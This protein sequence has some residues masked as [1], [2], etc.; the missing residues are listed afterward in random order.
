M[1]DFLLSGVD[2]SGYIS[3]A[4]LAICIVMFF[5]SLPLVNWVF[6]D[7]RA[8]ET[9][10][11]IWTGLVFAAAAGGIFVWL[12]IPI[13]FVGMLFYIVGVAASALSY[14]A[15]RNARVMD[16]ERVLTAEHIKSLFSSKEKR[17]SVLKGLTFIT[18]NNNEVPLPKPKTPDFFGYKAAHELF[19]DAI[20]RRASE[21]VLLPTHQDYRLIYQIDGV[22]M[23][24]PS[25]PRDQAEYFIRFIKNVADLVVKEKRKPQKGKF[26][27][28][29][30]GQSYE[31]ELTTAGSTAGE[32]LRLRC[33]L[34]QQVARLNELGLTPSQQDQLI[35]LRE[36]KQGVFIV[37]GPPKSGLTTTFYALLRN[38]DPFIN[39]I[40]TLE[41]E[42]SAELPN[43]TQEVFTLSDSGTTTF[44]NKLQ[45]LIRMGPD[46]VG[47]AECKDSETAR[48]VCNAAKDGKLLYTILETDSVINAL[49]LWIKLVQNKAEALRT[50]VGISNQRLLRKLCP[51]CKQ[52]YVPN[53]QLLKKFG[54]G[55]EK[56]KVL[57]RAGKVQY[58]K[59]GKPFT[60]EHCQGTGF[61]GRTGVFE[62]IIFDDQLRNAINQ[63]RS[64]AE[65]A[66]HL[67]GAKML[68][69]QEQAL[70]K[71]IAGETSINEIIR[72]FKVKDQQPKTNNA[73]RNNR[74]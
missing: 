49:L 68:Y 72:V 50:L 9:K 52:A 54:I 65:I 47:V 12:L 58:D 7:A 41:R 16:Y 5:L 39:S 36:L 6:S 23:K 32:Q 66:S 48:V 14:V 44:A 42:P 57:Y 46:I 37:S 34:N 55:P 61:V 60:C 8:V 25:I 30:E 62:T 69:L 45:A 40:H 24:R 27:I 28:E 20:W 11:A 29:R 18:A 59:H 2:Y 74:S 3:V 71:A 64:A 43:I 26:R 63:A 73:G 35:G 22:A 38:H 53:K 4:K 51:E 1:P 33:I 67:R 15:H 56:A 19:A 10:E 21:V 31:W 13:F 70:L 17:L